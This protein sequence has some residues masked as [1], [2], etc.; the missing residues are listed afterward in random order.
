MRSETQLFTVAEM[1]ASLRL[2]QAESPYGENCL[3]PSVVRSDEAQSFT[4]AE[5]PAGRRRL[6][7]G[8]DIGVVAGGCGENSTAGRQCDATRHSHSQRPKCPPAHAYRGGR[9]ARY[10]VRRPPRGC[11]DWRSGSGF[12][13]RSA[14]RAAPAS[15]A[16]SGGSRSAHESSRWIRSPTLEGRDEMRRGTT[17]RPRHS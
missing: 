5:M 1:P 4:V 17:L 2:R 11:R 10:G 15:K 7:G 8:A 6:R 16:P 14:L 13:R 12:E 9:V 3:W